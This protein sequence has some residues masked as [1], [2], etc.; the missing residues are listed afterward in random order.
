LLNFKAA[1]LYELDK[2]NR[3]SHFSFHGTHPQTLQIVSDAGTTSKQVLL[4]CLMCNWG[5]D[6]H[7]GQKYTSGLL[8]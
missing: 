6:Y 2:N 3:R 4:A 1:W 8:C 5:R 7:Q